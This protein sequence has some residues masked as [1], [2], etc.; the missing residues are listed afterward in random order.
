MFTKLF[1]KDLFERLISTL[2][3][4]ALGLFAADTIATINLEAALVTLGTAGVLVVLKVLAAG[5]VKNTLSPGSLA[6]ASPD[7]PAVSLEEKHDHA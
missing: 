3:Q 6:P 2:A 1:W 5:S 7:L 4:V